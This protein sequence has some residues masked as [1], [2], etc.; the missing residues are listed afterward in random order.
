M[1]E[2]MSEKSTRGLRESLAR[3]EV[4]AFV[5]AGLSIGAGL[6]GWFSLVNGLAERIGF[7]MPP[8]EWVTA[9]ILMDAAQDYIHQEGLNSLVIYLKNHLDTTGVSP[10]AAHQALVR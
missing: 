10:T 7:E 6:P 2:N 1:N 5:G 3:G 4:V 9:E 8:K